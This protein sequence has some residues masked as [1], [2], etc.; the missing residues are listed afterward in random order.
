MKIL[1]IGNSFSS[2]LTRYM[3]D[4]SDGELF[5]RNLYIGGC[6]LETHV[7]N[8][9][10]GADAYEYCENSEKLHMISIPDAVKAEDW[11]VISVQ[12]VSSLSGMPESYEPYLGE[13]IAY[14]KE[15]APKSKLVF[16]KT[17]AYEQTS[18][19]PGFVRYDCNRDLMNDMINVTVKALAGKYSLPVIPS[20]DAVAKARKM[21][22]FD[23]EVFGQPITRDGFHMN[24]PYGRYLIGLVAN[25]F[26]TGRSAASVTYIPDGADA[27]LCEKLKAL[28]D[29]IL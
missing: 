23:I 25:K 28:A 8:L 19:H 11:D 17:W 9:K 12:Q 7:N 10:S 5:I 29:T 15:E 1:F 20:G 21:P 24:I 2:D 27:G 18:D 16:H 6:S 4:I 26:F 3:Q 22:E 14:L 13:L